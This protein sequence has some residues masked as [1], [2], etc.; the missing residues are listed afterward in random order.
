[1]KFQGKLHKVLEVQEFKNNFKKRDI[2]MLDDTKPEYPQYITFSLLKDNV[3]KFDS[4][5]G[6]EIELEFVIN[7]RE[8]NEKFY[9]SLIC[10]KWRVIEEVIQVKEPILPTKEEVKLPF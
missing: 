8:Y 6:S 10:L 1:M 5:I 2:V 4:G 7:G 3:D 9:N